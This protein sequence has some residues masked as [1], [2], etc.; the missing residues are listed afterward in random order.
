M[1]QSAWQPFHGRRYPALKTDGQF[2]V[3]VI[4]GGITGLSAAFF[5]KQAGK[6]VCVVERDRIGD[7]D[8][9]H[10]TAHLTAV[11]DLRLTQLVKA[12]GEEAAKL[13]FQAGATA[14]DAI[15][16]IATEHN[17]TCEF[18]RVPGFLHASLTGEKDERKQLQ[19][20][21][22]L[23]TRL[24]INAQ[25]VDSVPVV[26]KPGIRFPDQA[27]FQPLAY[28]A[29]LA[30]LVQGDG[31]AI[32]ENTEVDDVEAAP[33]TVKAGKR[34]IV[35]NELVIA[36]H[37]PLMGIANLASA[38]VFQTKLASFSSYAVSAALTGTLR[39]EVSLWDTS[40]PYY[41]LRI[42]REKKNQRAIFGGEDHKT[43]QAA[44]TQRCYEK[45]ES[46]L[47]EILPG[48][49]V[50]RRWSGQVVETSDGLPFIGLMAEAQFVATGFA[51]NGMTLG[52]LAGMMARDCFTGAKNPWQELF[53]VDRKKIRG[54]AW[55]YLKENIDYPY[56]YL[57][58]RM[59]APEATSTRAVHR[60]EGKILKLDGRRVACSRD[61]KGKLTVLSAECTHMGCVVR[62]NRAER[63]WDCPCHGSRF[64]PDGQVLAGPAEKPLPPAELNAHVAASEKQPAPKKQPAAPKKKPAAPKAAAATRKHA[65]TNG[66]KPQP[67]VRQQQ[68]PSTNGR[69]QKHPHRRLPAAGKGR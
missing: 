5:L 21:A 12:F 18:R 41:Y 65:A 67:A 24:G 33:L 6:K 62:W 36:T 56:Y 3:V 49:K 64:H 57:K 16:T 32:H 68:P 28:L 30:Q 50:E 40:N 34:R 35:C 61:D 44:D 10:T 14:I 27:K 7:G 58:D 9:G 42:D 11:T 1:N 15:E 43:G 23:A 59:V 55:R 54:G 69:S 31:C 48:A 22:E 63:T 53:A 37:V 17:I 25:F 46:M 60:G 52:T 13:V 39:P 47:A 4:G 38:A 20:E 19:A 29:G 2:D 66:R 26:D 8:T 51:G 45:L